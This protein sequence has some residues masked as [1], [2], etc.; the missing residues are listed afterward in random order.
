VTIG[1]EAQ[2]TD[3]RGR[4]H[5][6]RLPLGRPLALQISHPRFEDFVIEK[7]RILL[8]SD[9]VAVQIFTLKRRR[10]GRARTAPRPLSELDGDTLP[11]PTGQ[12]FRVEPMPPN[13]IPSGDLLMVQEIPVKGDGV[14]LVSRFKGFADGQF[15]VRTVTIPR[16]RLPPALK[17]RDHLRFVLGEFRRARVDPTSIRKEI[18]LRA[19]RKAFPGRT[20]VRTAAE[21]R[22]AVQKRVEFLVQRGF[23]SGAARG[24]GDD[25]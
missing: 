1:R 13:R 18:A 21:R 20:S 6:L 12:P 15:V 5:L 19:M 8:D 9:L 22:H 24:G 23:F 2:R 3:V 14:K 10:R 16:D 11:T 25:V 17:E 4:F 7:P